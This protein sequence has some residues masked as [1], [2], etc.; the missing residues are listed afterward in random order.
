MNGHMVT[1]E[2]FANAMNCVQIFSGLSD[3]E[4]RRRY[5]R[6]FGD[7][8]DL[9][10]S[11]CPRVNFGR[12]RN[13]K[14]P[15]S[16]ITYCDCAALLG[17]TFRF[18]D[19]ETRINFLIEYANE[20]SRTT[21]VDEAINQLKGALVFLGNAGRDDIDERSYKDLLTRVLV[22]L[23]KIRGGQHQNILG[24]VEV[25]QA[26]RSFRQES[27]DRSMLLSQLGRMQLSRAH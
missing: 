23:L 7:V 25:C 22:M 20:L 15:F 14:L 4:F 24:V 5:S 1:R 21:R 26:I 16:T 9:I 18:R 19:L 17:G 6:M 2:L 11:L 27:I 10:R 3:A 12:E 13:H 8:E